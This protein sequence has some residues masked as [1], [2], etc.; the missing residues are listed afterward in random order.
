MIVTNPG[1]SLFR[2]TLHITVGTVP[3]SQ[4]KRLSEGRVGA[5]AV[6]GDRLPAIAGD[7]GAVWAES[8]AER[9]KRLRGGRRV[10]LPGEPI[11][12]ADTEVVDRRRGL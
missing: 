9:P 5:A 1:G 7:D 6:E 3:V 11:A 10:E 8:I 2:A 12:L 4:S